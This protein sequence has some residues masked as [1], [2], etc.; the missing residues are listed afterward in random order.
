MK[1]IG[2]D[3]LYQRGTFM[4]KSPEVEK[5]LSLCIHIT[6]LY[7]ENKWKYPKASQVA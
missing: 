3:W 7:K 6:D 5:Q 4:S 1:S 2:Q